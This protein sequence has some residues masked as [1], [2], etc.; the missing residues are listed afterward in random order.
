MDNHDEGLN[1][2][3]GLSQLQVTASNHALETL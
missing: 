1:L 2:D 3:P